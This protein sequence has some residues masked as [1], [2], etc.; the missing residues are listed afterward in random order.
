MLADGR[1]R[2]FVHA[3]MA[4]EF[5]TLPC[6]VA[7]REAS[8]KSTDLVSYSADCCALGA[9]WPVGS[10]PSSAASMLAFKAA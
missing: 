6:S 7:N 1:D 8:V 9:E 2:V 5:A 10:D 3:G 4:I